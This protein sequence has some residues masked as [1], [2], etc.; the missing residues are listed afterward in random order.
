MNDDA[1]TMLPVLSFLSMTQGTREKQMIGNSV[2]SIVENATVFAKNGM[3][4]ATAFAKNGMENATVFAKNGM[5]NATAK[6][7]VAPQCRRTRRQPPPPALAPPSFRAACSVC[8]TKE[9]T[10]RSI[11]QLIITS[12]TSGSSNERDAC[13]GCAATNRA[14]EKGVEAKV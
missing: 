3:E 10:C 4:N 14:L 11:R 8:A 5:E 13:S 7:G 6:G 12:V 2:Y 9:M 1:F